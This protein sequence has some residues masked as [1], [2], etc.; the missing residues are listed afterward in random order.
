MRKT[1]YIKS[2]RRILL[3]LLVAWWLGN[4][5]GAWAALLL[6]LGDSR[7]SISIVPPNSVGG[8][9]LL[10][11]NALTLTTIA[12]VAGYMFLD[13]KLSSPHPYNTASFWMS[14]LGFLMLALVLTLLLRDV[15]LIPFVETVGARRVTWLWL[16]AAVTATTSAMLKERHRSVSIGL[17]Y[18]L[19]SFLVVS[20][21]SG[22]HH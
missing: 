14:F 19:V 2:P 15:G 4:M 12:L 3:T 10:V 8:W 21:C 20:V 7:S 5:L 6:G 18:G 1:P 17:T 16:V 9:I 22:L 13:R 11:Y